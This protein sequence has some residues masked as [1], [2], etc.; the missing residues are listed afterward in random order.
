VGERVLPHVKAAGAGLAL[1]FCSLPRIAKALRWSRKGFA[2]KL[3]D[4]LAAVRAVLFDKGEQFLVYRDV[5][6]GF[7]LILRD[8]GPAALP[9]GI[10]CHRLAAAF[11]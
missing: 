6:F 10:G 11:S 7:L 4:I 8:R 3:I 5:D 9:W 2:E 1:V